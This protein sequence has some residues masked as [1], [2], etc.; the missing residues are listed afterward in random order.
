MGKTYSELLDEISE[1]EAGQ[2]LRINGIE[3]IA[4]FDLYM[5]AERDGYIIYIAGEVPPPRFIVLRKP[6]DIISGEFISAYFD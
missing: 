6:K 4:N 2:E 1:L 3:F 5:R